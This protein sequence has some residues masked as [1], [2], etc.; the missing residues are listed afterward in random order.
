[1]NSTCLTGHGIVNVC[2]PFFFR[3]GCSRS[4]CDIWKYCFFK[5]KE[6][7]QRRFLQQR[8]YHLNSFFLSLNEKEGWDM[9][10]EYEN[11]LNDSKEELNDLMEKAEAQKQKIKTR[12]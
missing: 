9:Y 12:R 5:R 4:K 8:H 2:Y 7:A 6:I 11:M 3:K 10:K 1:M